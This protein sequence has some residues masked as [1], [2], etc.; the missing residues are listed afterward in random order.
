MGKIVVCMG[1]SS[2]GKDTVVKELLRENKYHFQKI[3]PSTTRPIRFG[4]IDG[5]EYYF[6]TEEEMWRLDRRHK[7]IERRQ[8]NTE[9]GT[10]YYYTTNQNIDLENH[11][12]ITV[13]TLEG[14]DCFIEYY[15]RDKIISLL[16]QLEDGERFQ[17]ALNRE[18]E[19]EN[20]KYKELCRRFLADSRDFSLENIEKRIITKTIN[21]QGDIQ[22]TVKEVN[23]VLGLYL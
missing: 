8:Y 22:Q 7:I 5:R 17:R 15:G 11:N 1:K 10:W 12:Y 16:I 19:Q 21:N 13:N 20:P 4:E 18:K 2:S 3:I 23:K 6:N 9:Q 14:L